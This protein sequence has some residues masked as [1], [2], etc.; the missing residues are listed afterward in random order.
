MVIATPPLEMAGEQFE[1]DEMGGKPRRSYAPLQPFLLRIPKI[2]G[3]GAQTR[4]GQ[5]RAASEGSKTA[6]GTRLANKALHTLTRRRSAPAV[7]LMPQI[8]GANLPPTHSHPTATATCAE[9]AST[10]PSKPGWIGIHEGVQA[11]AGSIEGA[12]SKACQVVPPLIVPGTRHTQSAPQLLK[13]T[14]SL[15]LVYARTHP[16]YVFSMRTLLSLDRMLPFEEMVAR[17]L[18]FE[19]EENVD[20]LF[21]I[22]HQWTSFEDPDPTGT[23]LATLQA[24]MRATLAGKLSS[25]FGTPDEWAGFARTEHKMNAMKLPVMS[26]ESLAAEAAEGYVWLDYAC[27]PQAAGAAA[28]RA[29]AIRSIPH[30]IDASAMFV[31]LCPRIEHSDLPGTFCDYHTWR[32]RGWCRLE[33]QANELKITTTQHGDG[34]GAAPLTVTRRPLIVHSATHVTSTTAFDHF[35]MLGQRANSIFTGEFT[36]CALNHQKTAHDGTTITIPCDKE[37]IRPIVSGLWRRK[38]ELM[39]R[40]APG[41]RHAIA[42]RYISHQKLM[43]AESVEDTEENNDAPELQ[44]LDDVKSKY[45]LNDPECAPTL[46]RIMEDWWRETDFTSGDWVADDGAERLADLRVRTDKWAAVLREGNVLPLAL[47]YVVAEGNLRMTKLLVET[48]GA[49]AALGT[50]WGAMSLLEYAAGKG[51]ARVV[52]YLLTLP[53]CR[54]EINRR[55]NHM[56]ISAI[57]RA[58]KAGFVEVLHLLVSHGADA[59]SAVRVN[60]ETPAHGAA[61]YGHLNVLRALASLGCDLDAA[62]AKGR[63]PLE[64][65][66]YYQQTD[67]T[68]WLECH[69]GLA[70][71]LQSCRRFD[72]ACRRLKCHAVRGGYD[73][74][75]RRS[76]GSLASLSSASRGA[77]AQLPSLRPSKETARGGPTLTKDGDAAAKEG[78]EARDG[79]GASLSSS[80]SS[81][82]PSNR[83]ARGC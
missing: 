58:A 44:T 43:Q 55:S 73:S 71:D 59:K 75:V 49:D 53:E 72:E 38:I 8:T 62:D 66:K 20:N 68:L 56:G 2:G 19:A 28:Q 23:Q 10:N 13:H 83:S 30:Y 82:P 76:T 26:E 39:K 70:S 63:T 74:L 7:E 45:M 31:A 1:S 61:M 34:A 6:A 16:M 54:A 17:G 11:V 41:V 15:E 65:A 35:Y 21:F 4:Y 81:R 27:V 48:H 37:A 67:A 69:L 14:H 78:K 46:L 50:W 80:G 42:W 77:L 51:H 9:C 60:G 18:L 3:A 22:S 5:R 57:D 40:G 29:A 52:D 12:V 79:L 24:V 33:E 47:L 36:C 25:L 32:R 64:L